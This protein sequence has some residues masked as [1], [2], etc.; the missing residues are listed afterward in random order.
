MSLQLRLKHPR[1]TYPRSAEV[2]YVQMPWY[3]LPLSGCLLFNDKPLGLGKFI[4]VKVH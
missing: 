3:D 1:Q 4:Y 2:L